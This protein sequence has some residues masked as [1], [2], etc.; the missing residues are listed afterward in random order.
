MFKSVDTELRTGARE[1]KLA[2]A[3]KSSGAVP[4]YEILNVAGILFVPL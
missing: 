2:G 4:P 1:P 3:I